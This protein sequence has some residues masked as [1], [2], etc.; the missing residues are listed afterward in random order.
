MANPWTIGSTAVRHM[1]DSSLVGFGIPSSRYN[2]RDQYRRTYNDDQRLGAGMGP[3]LGV[4]LTAGAG[5]T[6]FKS[7]LRLPQQAT[8][9]PA[10]ARAVGVAALGAAAAVAVKKSMEI[11]EDDGNFA[12]VGTTAGVLG[13]AAAG[14]AIGSKFAGKYA[15]LVTAGS[16]IAGG[17]A[18]HFAGAAIKNGDGHIGEE[19]KQDAQVDRNFGDRLKSFARGAFDHFVEVG[20]ITQ[21]ISL[22][23]RWNMHDTVQHKYSNNEYAG[24][25]HGDL[26]AAAILGGG[27]LAVG[28]GLMGVS[29]L[30]AK[31]K[32]P[33]IAG[34]ALAHDVLKQG[35]LTAGAA[36][37]ANLPQQ[38]LERLTSSNQ[39][40]VKTA[41]VAAA[42]LGITALATWKGYQADKDKLGAAPAAAIA[43][44]TLAATAG[45][46]FAVSRTAAF[47]AMDAA[48]QAANS[49]LVAAA[50]IGVVSAARLPVQQF[51]SDAKD[52]RA[53]RGSTDHA[54]SGTVASVSGLAAGF[55]A[56]KALSNSKLI[57][58][59][60]IQLG[61]FHIPKVAI[62]AAGTAAGAAAAGAAGY[63]LS[64]TMPD[65]ATVGMSTAGGAALGAL[66]G[67]FALKGVGVVPGMIGGAVLGM[68]A[69]SLFKHD[70]NKA[71]AAAG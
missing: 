50:L 46:A 9:F 16:A 34:S 64:A 25:M 18:G 58:D 44:G 31:G 13:G 35:P 14:I 36:S 68:T 52:A 17:I 67:K 10:V 15:P 66:A 2:A 59:G 57:P 61:K 40:L 22:G 7:G 29:S 30:A 62:V 65:L 5:A 63:G 54:V 49:M 32:G 42:G 45:T 41:G 37:L 47:R 71:V 8:N 69:S 56:F 53:H 27:A 24:A 38:V 6:W 60:G 48:P 1:V 23:Y 28:A 20:P 19:F 43:A 26:G 70:E 21:G 55:G 39:S 3:A 11:S 51:I 4:A 33:I 12:A